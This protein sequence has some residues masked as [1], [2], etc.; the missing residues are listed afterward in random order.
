M[1]LGFHL[2]H[3]LVASM[4]LLDVSMALSYQ[5]H[6]V[7]MS[8]AGALIVPC[9]RV[10]SKSMC[11]IVVISRK[12]CGD[13]FELKYR[14]TMKSKLIE[15]LSVLNDLCQSSI[16]LSNFHID[17]S[18]TGNFDRT[19]VPWIDLNF[20]E[21]ICRSVHNFDSFPLNHSIRWPWPEDAARTHSIRWLSP[22]SDSTD[23]S[24]IGCATFG[25][26][27]LHQHFRHLHHR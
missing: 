4:R 11:P 6:V 10:H 25:W 21:L 9:V 14:W 26:Y 5:Y 1:S 15:I 19:A 3:L 13:Y 24:S 7:S 17:V 16:G 27:C 18:K 23:I 20:V 8:Y 22:C 12:Y 2:I